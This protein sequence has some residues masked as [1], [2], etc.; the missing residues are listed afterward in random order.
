MYFAVVNYVE[1]YFLRIL[2]LETQKSVGSYIA[3]TRTFSGPQT[4]INRRSVKGY[5]TVNWTYILEFGG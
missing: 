2:N 3:A 5:Q 4:T 1:Q